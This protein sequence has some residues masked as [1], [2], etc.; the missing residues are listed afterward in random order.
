MAPIRTFDTVVSDVHADA[1]AEQRRR[2]RL[3][4]Q[5]VDEQPLLRPDAAR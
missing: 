1:E 3:A 4:A 5:H 2:R